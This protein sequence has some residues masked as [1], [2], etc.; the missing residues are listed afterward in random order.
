MD[1]LEVRENIN[2][3]IGVRTLLV[4]DVTVYRADAQGD[5]A[6]IDAGAVALAVEV[7]SPGETGRRIADKVARYHDAGV[8]AVWSIDLA[9]DS[10]SATATATSPT[11]THSPAGFCAR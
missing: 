9:D 10:V 6:W 3:R 8:A 5:M 1:P 7:L 2:V 4:P 11:A